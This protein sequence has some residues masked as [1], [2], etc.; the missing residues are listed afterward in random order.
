MLILSRSNSVKVQASSRFI[1][2]FCLFVCVCI[3]C[4]FFG[5]F[6][7]NS[8]FAFG[9]CVSVLFTLESKYPFGWLFLFSLVSSRMTV[10]L[11]CDLF[12]P[13]YFID[14]IVIIICNTSFSRS[15]SFHFDILSLCLSLCLRNRLGLEFFR[16]GTLILLLHV[17]FLTRSFF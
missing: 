3:E 7:V 15:I 4:G 16:C 2:R 9:V 8:L 5:W 17:L 13:V 11:M 12:V 6:F 14:Q 10:L 1:D